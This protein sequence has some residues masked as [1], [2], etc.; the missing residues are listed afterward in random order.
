[1]IK[2]TRGEKQ[3]NNNWG[4][5]QQCKKKTPIKSKTTLGHGVK[6]LT[7]IQ[8]K[9]LNRVLCKWQLLFA[10]LFP[11]P[12]FFCLWDPSSPTRDWI[13]DPAVKVCSPNHGAPREFPG[14]YKL[15]QVPYTQTFKVWTFKG[16]N[17]HCINVRR[18]PGCNCSSPSISYG[19][20][21]SALPS[22]ASS[23]S[24]SQQ[25]FLPVDSTPA[26][27]CQLLYWTTVLFKVLPCKTR[28]DFF[29]FVFYVLFVWINI[30]QFV[31]TYLCD[32]LLQYS[33][34]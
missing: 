29:V 32:Y 18:R 12:T 6:E 28:N 33:T 9:L 31:W 4:M 16:V 10:K 22:P 20:R 7:R 26:P 1:M 25:L 24:S 8:A 17:M 19:W 5:Q 34:L 14:K 3:T 13:Q 15:Q 21:P 11:W 30:T 27:A 23:I 2:L